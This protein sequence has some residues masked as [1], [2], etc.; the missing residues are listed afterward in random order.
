M[1]SRLHKCAKISHIDIKLE[2]VS[3]TW[4]LNADGIYDLKQIQNKD[5]VLSAFRL[6]TMNTLSPG[7]KSVPT[8][9]NFYIERLD[10]STQHFRILVTTTNLYFSCPAKT[11]IY[12]HGWVGKFLQ[13]SF[14]IR[15]IKRYMLCIPSTWYHI[16]HSAN[17]IWEIYR[18]FFS[19]YIWY[20]TMILLQVFSN[21]YQGF[22]CIDI[23]CLSGHRN[24]YIC[25]FV[26]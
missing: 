5:C 1:L 3:L 23:H 9:A 20:S 18:L 13:K 12:Q 2:Q 19:P 4:K 14:D 11:D 22:L 15:D 17:G 6:K 21:L 16:W 24:M 7:V 8:N 10:P 25:V 26:I